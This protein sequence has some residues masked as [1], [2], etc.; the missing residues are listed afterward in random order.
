MLLEFWDGAPSQ[1]PCSVGSL[2]FPL[3][4]GNLINGKR[5]N[6]FKIVSTYLQIAQEA[7]EFRLPII[8]YLVPMIP[9]LPS[10]L[11]SLFQL[12]VPV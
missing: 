8:T 10:I 1:A 6:V 7:G 2:L 5:K 11:V 4:P 9:W 3:L 12:P